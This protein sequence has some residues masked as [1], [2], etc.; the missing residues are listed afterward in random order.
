M[1]LNEGSGLQTPGLSSALI[2]SINDRASSDLPWTKYSGIFALLGRLQRDDLI[3]L[4]YKDKNY[5]YDHGC[6][7]KDNKQL[8]CAK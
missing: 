1:A 5:V 3:Y 7:Y 4:N 8:S 6:V 2:L